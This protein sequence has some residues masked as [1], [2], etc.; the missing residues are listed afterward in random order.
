MEEQGHSEMEIIP[1][2]SH[3]HI[4]LLKSNRELLVTHI[5]N[6]QC[7]VDN[8]LKNDYFSAEDAEIVCACP[9]Q[10]DKVRKI[11]DLVQSKG[12]EVSEFFLYLLQQLADAYVDLRPWLLEIGF[13]PSLLTQSKV[14]VNTDPV[15]RYTQQLRHHL[16]RDSKFVLC[17]A[18]K[19]ELLLE[20]I[21]MDTIMELVGF[22][23]E[24]LGSLNS[25]AC[26]LDHTTGILNEQGETIFILGDAGVGKSM[27][28]Q[29][30]Q[31]LWAT[32]RLD[33]GVKFF[34]HFRCRMFS[35]FKESDR[36]CLQDLL[37]K[38]Y[39]YPERDPEE[40]FAFLLRFPHVAL[41]TFDGL[42][43]L[44]SDLDLSR[45]PDS[46][47][48]WEPAHPLVLLANLLS[49]K[50][51]KGASKL[52]TA[53]T[54]IE[55][56]RQFLRKKVLLRGFS[57]SH[58]RAYARR[59]FPERALQDRLL[60]QLEANPNLCSLCSVPLFCWIIFRCF[61]HFR[62]AFEGS[63]QLPDCTMTLTDVF[64]L[65]TEVHLNRMQPSSLVQRNTRSPVETLHAGR[66][67][68][69]SLGQ[70][71]HRGMEKSLFV[72]TQEEVQASGLQER[73]M[74]LGFLRALPELGPGGD[75]QSY[76]FF[77]LTL[78]AFFTAFFLVLDDRVG[79]QELL[80][81]FQEWMPPAGAATT[82]C[83]PPFLPF[84]CLQGSGPAREDLFKNKDH[85]QFTNLFLCGLLSKAK[86][87]L[88]RHLVPAAALRRKRKALW[89]HLFSSLRGYLKSLPR[90]QVESF[91]QVQAM[92][93]FIW[94]L[95]CIYETQSQK[96]GQLAARG[97]C[98]NYLK[99][100]YCN[101]CSADCSALSFVLHHFPKRLALDL[102]N[103][104]LN[105]YG[106]REL[107]PC[108][109]RLTVLRLSVNQITDGGVKVLSEELTK[110]KIVTYL[111]LYN[112]QITDVGARYVTKILDECKGLTHLKL[113]KNK[114]TS[115]GGKY[116]ALAVKNSK[117]ISE[118]GLASNGISTE[119]GKSLARALQQNTSLEIL[120]LTQ[121]ELNDEV[122]ESLAEMLK[123]NQTL[124]HLW[125]I[126]N[127]ITAKGTAQLAD[128]LQS[129]TGITEICL[130][131]NLIKPEEAKVYEDEK[132]IICF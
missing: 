78:Q 91:N 128:A 120:W 131:G 24:S 77:H 9:T 48:P 36:L 122:A 59:M 8:L 88:L 99:L 14:V 117:S 3:P 124:K 118:V 116:L 6:T 34:F 96:V 74:Q 129:N 92:P 35:C 62:A 93:T 98:A 53:R 113:G 4:Q 15:S 50:L 102:D 94:M 82:S 33:A 70:V 37:F 86:Q 39:C 66:D 87:K 106:V 75:Q 22:S 65:V 121:N 79:T 83:Y 10:P 85:F 64:L 7:L 38:H 30:L 12:E 40:V 108:F 105:D 29:R 23:N 112:N 58:L 71:A 21:Y 123:V 2:E 110:Y 27:L 25:L 68:L 132:R 32:G 51:L 41:F 89:A 84:Q 43:E 73:D 67:T 130:N 11:L 16:G 81:F 95:R 100:T 55:V 97:I 115:E 26:L 49:G 127:Q 18:Q 126:Q 90:V 101:A 1:S 19:E 76:E 103:N 44:H 54:G 63:P 17:Y 107:Q 60:S 20:E 28:L 57:P 5:R 125:L 80:R 111:G 72:F 119:G 52:L 47:C 104:N 69:C 45:V 109:S 114:I 13:S 31:S 61:Q 42:D 46:S 56:P